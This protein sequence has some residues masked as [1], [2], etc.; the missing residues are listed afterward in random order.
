MIARPLCTN[1][2]TV[3][4]VDA[5]GAAGQLRRHL[6]PDL[7]HQ[8]LGVMVPKHLRK[9]CG[10]IPM[11]APPVSTAGLQELVGIGV[12]AH[13]ARQSASSGGGRW[14]PVGVGI[15]A[16]ANMQPHAGARATLHYQSERSPKGELRP[17]RKHWEL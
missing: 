1:L 4:R 12:P 5:V 11:P 7:L 3:V 13:I 2:G 14:G 8:G 16:Q 9:P 17:L 15:F 6:L 10:D